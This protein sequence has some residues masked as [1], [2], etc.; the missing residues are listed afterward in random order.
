MRKR[1]DRKY[2]EKDTYSHQPLGSST[3]QKK[4]EK[5]GSRCAFLMFGLNTP[6]PSWGFLGVGFAVIWPLWAGLGLQSSYGALSP[7][8]QGL[9]PCQPGILAL[10]ECGAGHCPHTNAPQNVWRHQSLTA[11]DIGDDSNPT[12]KGDCT[13]VAPQ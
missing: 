6:W 10:G 11:G 7:V 13:E 2:I 1:E 8:C 12:A 4:Q 9:V 3:A 5:V